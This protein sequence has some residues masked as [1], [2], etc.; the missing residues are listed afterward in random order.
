MVSVDTN[1]ERTSGITTVRVV[2]TNDHTTPQAV[3]LQ[4]NLDGPVWPPRRGGV[5]DPRWADDVWEA[6]IRPGRTHGVGFA[7]PAPPTEPLV[8]VVS[9]E[10]QDADKLRSD[11]EVLAQLDDWRPRNEVLEREP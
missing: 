9:S 8:E 7:S 4:S 3:R 11:S 10:R 1:A 2:L 5:D 6:T